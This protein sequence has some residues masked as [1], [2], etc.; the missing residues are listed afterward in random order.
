MSRSR[1]RSID[2]LQDNLSVQPYD[3]SFPR[4]GKWNPEEE[5]Y[6]NR[7]IQEFESGTLVDCEEGSTL[8]SYLAKKLN[9]A[10]MRI[11]KKFAGLCIG[12]HVF[13]RRDGASNASF[14]SNASASAVI[15][16]KNGND[17]YILSSSS[18]ST[19][20]D[21]IDENSDNFPLFTFT[22]KVRGTSNVNR[23]QR[24]VSIGDYE[25]CDSSKIGTNSID[26][27]ESDSLLKPQDSNLMIG[28]DMD[29][30]YN[31]SYTTSYSSEVSSPYDTAMCSTSRS[32]SSEREAE[33][34]KDVLM[35]FCG[36]DEFEDTQKR[37]DNSGNAGYNHPTNGILTKVNSYSSLLR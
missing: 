11:S 27:V 2:S 26:S 24:V 35:F 6:A 16:L 37:L 29:E 4:S 28:I 30:M 8:R 22:K 17:K 18:V 10:P 33:E 3:N 23:K 14:G 32:S 34:W 31:S 19:I 12:K 36:M 13:A 21:P 7:L 20:S 15:N 9:C 5:L 1:K 25:S